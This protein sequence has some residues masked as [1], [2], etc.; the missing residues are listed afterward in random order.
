MEVSLKAV[1][2]TAVLALIVC[3]STV[4]VDAVE[5]QKYDTDLGQKWSYEIQFVFT[6]GSAS[7]ITWDFGDGSEPISD[8]AS[9]GES[10]YTVWN[11]SHVYAEK[12]V[13]YVTQTVEGSSGNMDTAI[14]RIEIMGYPHVTLVYNNGQSNGTIQMESGGSLSTA[15][16]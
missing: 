16:A 6:G 5:E 15:A 14:F 13:Y 2:I 7:K 1:A 3:F 4:S 9:D 10:D 8:D 12:G 11:P